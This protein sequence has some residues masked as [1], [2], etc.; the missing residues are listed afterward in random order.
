MADDPLGPG[1]GQ[2][3]CAG[4][5]VAVQVHR[6]FGRGTIPDQGGRIG[7][8]DEFVD[9]GDQVDDL[10]QP[11]RGR[12]DD[13]LAWF[14]PAQGTQSRDRG[15]KLTEAPSLQH[16]YNRHILHLPET[17]ADQTF[18]QGNDATGRFCGP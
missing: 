5:V 11:M 3:S 6:Q 4:A 1:I 15:E 7:G 8:G 2:R 12:Q 14:G 10:L 13:P 16:E 9:R 17:V 18:R